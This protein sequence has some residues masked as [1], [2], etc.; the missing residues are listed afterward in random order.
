MTPQVSLINQLINNADEYFDL[1]KNE[2]GSI[3]A[4]LEKLRECRAAGGMKQHD[5]WQLKYSAIVV[6]MAGIELAERES[7]GIKI[8]EKRAAEVWFDVH[9]LFN[10][11]LGIYQ[12][13]DA[14]PPVVADMLFPAECY[15]LAMLTEVFKLDGKKIQKAQK[16]YLAKV[17]REYGIKGKGF[18]KS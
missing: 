8:T 15:Y 14:A 11:S 3:D 13:G 9:T 17:E 10:T 12:F 6:G 2:I 18:G 7:Q 5:D 16:K 1:A 4:A